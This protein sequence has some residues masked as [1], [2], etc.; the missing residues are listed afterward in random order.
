MLQNVLAASGNGAILRIPHGKLDLIRHAPCSV[1]SKM[2]RGA[3]VPLALMTALISSRA[4]IVCNRRAAE[5][6][7]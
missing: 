3:P 1:W 5:T 2:L 4:W 6:R 7:V